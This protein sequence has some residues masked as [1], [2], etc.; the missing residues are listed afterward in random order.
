MNIS[1]KFTEISKT[2]PVKVED[3][4]ENLATSVGEVQTVTKYIGGEVYEGNYEVTPKLEAQSL[5]TKNKVLT[6][7]VTVKSIPIFRVTSPSGG[8]TLYIAKEM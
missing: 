8:T 2:L 1:V 4:L 3:N 6:D 5:P 7:D